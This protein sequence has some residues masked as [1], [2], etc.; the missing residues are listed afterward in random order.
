M[1]RLNKVVMR[2]V[3]VLLLLQYFA[4]SSLAWAD[5]STN[6][7][8]NPGFEEAADW[9][10]ANWTVEGATGAVSVKSGNSIEGSKALEYWSDS[11]FSFTVS[12]TVYGLPDGI[13][14]FSAQVQG[15]GGESTA[16]LYADNG[17]GKSTV[18]YANTGWNKWTQPRLEDIAVK[19]G[20]VTVGVEIETTKGLWGVVDDVV[21]T[22]VGDLPA[23]PPPVTNPVRNSGFEDEAEWGLAFWKVEGATGAVSVKSGNSIEGSK[24]LEYWNGS[25]YSFTVAQEVNSIPNGIYALSAQVQG[26]G[27]ESISRL[28]AENGEGKVTQG[29]VN[30]G[31]SKWSQPR[32]EGIMVKNGQV[33]IGFEIETTKGLW[34]VIDDVV[35]TKIGDLPTAP[36]TV[37]SIQ[38]VNVATLV[39]DV[40]VLPSVVTAVYSDT[41]TKSV[42]VAWNPIT[43]DLLAQPGSFEVVGAVSGT[44]LL[45]KATVTVSYRSTDVNQDSLTNV[46]DLAIAMYYDGYQAAHEEWEQAKAVDIN[47]D[48]KIDLVDRQFIGEAI[49]QVK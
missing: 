31:W 16:H 24:A 40:P 11:S 32:L 27:G 36:P 17:E 12:Q 14:A 6:Y 4:F 34:G 30:T 26:D 9:G 22:R 8:Q 23:D 42:P 3:P 29:F 43:P 49:R 18:S 28:Y 21:L 19:N 1:R 5:A 2:L 47:N 48:G 46:G 44:E 38:P 15:D 10:L 39:N 41:T 25:A 33:T 37:T 13:Y 7:I 35:L 20:Q 45:A